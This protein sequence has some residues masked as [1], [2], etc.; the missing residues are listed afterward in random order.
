MLA[1]RVGVLARGQPAAGP[2]G[3]R[4]GVDFEPVELGQ[5]ERQAAV[6]DP[7]GG[8]AVPAVPDRQ[9]GPGIARER[10]DPGDLRG[11]A[12]PDDRRRA[13]VEAAGK[14]GARL[15]VVGI[16]GGDHAAVEHAAQL[17]DGEQLL[18]R[19]H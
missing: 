9:L 16:L 15:V 17:V 5:V 11:V 3:A 12:G 18:D 14:D 8:A 10:D 4:L 2:G 7:E 19:G 1:R 6:D 13:A